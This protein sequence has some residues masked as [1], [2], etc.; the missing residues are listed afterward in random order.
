MSTLEWLKSTANIDYAAAA[1]YA[2]ALAAEGYNNSNTI[3][4]ECSKNPSFLDDFVPKRSDR[5]KKLDALEST[6]IV[7]DSVRKSPT[8][9]SLHT[10]NTAYS[11]TTQILWLL[12]WFVNNIGVTLV[13]KAAFSNVDFKYPACLS[14]IHMF[15]NTV[16]AVSYM[17]FMGMKNKPLDNAGQR[18]MVIF[19]VIFAANITVGNTSLKYVSVNFNQ[20]MRSLVPAIVMGVNL[21]QGKSFSSAKLLSVLPIVLGVAMATFG[22]M[23][24]SMIGLFM[25]ILCVLLAAMKV[26]VSGSML[27]G[28]YKLDAFDLL[29][30]M[31][32]LSFMW[33]I[34]TSWSTGEI[35]SILDRWDE[36][37]GTWAWHVRE[38]FLSSKF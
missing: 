29:S 19:S 24:Y 31:A 36:L 21:C 33:M 27:T 28:E 4:Q 22:D 20:V 8:K 13:N 16:G 30:R 10:D 34:I 7:D 23:R 9:S 38:A 37:S 2:A 17:A 5:Q 11:T 3:K 12:A 35:D 18:M 26:I 14:A 1:Q 32:P 6:P 25:T 15:C